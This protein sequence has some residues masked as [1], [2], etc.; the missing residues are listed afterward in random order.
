MPKPNIL[1]LTPT[2]KRPDCLRNLLACF[3]A[4]DYEHKHLL[5]Y[6]DANQFDELLSKNVTV[7]VNKKYR[8]QNLPTKFNTMV[9]FANKV[10][11]LEFDIIAIGEDDDVYL[12]WHLSAIAA[13]YERGGE[14]FISSEIWS[15]YNEQKKG[16][17]LEQSGGRFH[18]STAFTT[19]LFDK[20]GGYPITD[21]LNF[22][23]Q[24]R[25]RMLNGGGVVEDYLMQC[26]GMKPSYTYRWGNREY[27]GSAAGDSGY[28]KLWDDLAKLPTPHQGKLIPQFDKETK[29]LYKQL[30]GIDV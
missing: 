4:Q 24:M 19:N 22:D 21:E 29:N 5:V 23:Q 13:A 25:A 17:H 2:Y 27:H 15:T 28:R 6:D 18:A 16:A 11:G 8:E 20:V 3:L 9:L 14:Y 12:P 10:L 26:S 7:S 1:M 30:A